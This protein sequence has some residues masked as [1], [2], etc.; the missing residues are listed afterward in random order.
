MCP[1]RSFVVLPFNPLNPNFFTTKKKL[2]YFNKKN[3][4]V[5]ALTMA[6]LFLF[7]LP[8]KA[9]PGG[10]S[11]EESMSFA[12]AYVN[13]MQI[14]Q[15]GQQQ[16]IA[17]IEEHDLTVQ[18][19]NEINMQAQQ[20]PLED[21]D[22]TEEEAEAYVTVI[23]IIE[24]IQV[25]QESLLVKAVEDSGLEMKKFEEIMMEFQQNPE[26]QQRVQELMR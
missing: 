25:E 20:V 24:E 19:F 14:S 5:A 11:D 15:M 26:L 7:A 1:P 12:N 22:M 13:L 8:V 6:L 21:V 23:A 2:M 16:M 17:E 9:N 3:Q 18:R 10:F 4:I